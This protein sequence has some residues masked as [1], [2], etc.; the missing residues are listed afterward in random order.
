VSFLLPAARKWTSP[1]IA[2]IIAHGCCLGI[3]ANNEG[4]GC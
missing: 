3:R 1:I 4:G 2:I